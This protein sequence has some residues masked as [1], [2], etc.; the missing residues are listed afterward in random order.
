MN[1]DSDAVRR[2]L[3]GDDSGYRDLLESY[4]DRVYSFILR[5]VGSA[6]DA[7]DLAQDVFLKAF[8]KLD[9]YDPT[10]PFLSWVFRIAH[11]SAI[12]HLRARKPQSL[13]LD[14]DEAL[15]RPEG[16]PGP[17]SAALAS[18]QAEYIDALISSLPPLYREA[19]L[20]RHREDMDVVEIARVLDLPEGTVK[21]RLFRARN[22]LKAKLD[23]TQP[24]SAP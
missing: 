18:S 17:E 7:E 10:R 11:N 21:I 6:Q 4:R 19:L 13:S 22:L 15:E 2:A 5:L 20:L 12:D 16:G 23:E 8:T 24:A 9:S 1:E 14:A 3:A